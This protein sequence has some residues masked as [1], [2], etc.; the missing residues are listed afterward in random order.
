[1]DRRL[2]FQQRL[3]GRPAQRDRRHQGI[4]PSDPTD[5]QTHTR[6]GTRDSGRAVLG[7]SGLVG[8]E[9]PAQPLLG[10]LR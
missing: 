10:T 5:T 1:M 3:V 8:C 4:A 2:V 6:D 7:R 9:V